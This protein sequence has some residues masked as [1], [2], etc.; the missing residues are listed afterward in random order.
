MKRKILLTFMLCLVFLGTVVFAAD[1]GY[2]F[3]LKYEGKV[4]VDEAKASSVTLT[5]TDA[6]PYTNVRIKVDIVSGPATPTLLAYDSNGIGYNIAEIGFWGPEAGFAVGGTFTNETPVTATFPQVGTYVINLSLIDVANNDAII[7]SKEF[8]VTVVT[9]TIEE[10]AIPENNVI[11]NT[12]TTTVNNT[13]ANIPQAGI[14]WWAY[15]L[16]IAAVIV[17]AWAIIT[18]IKNK[19]N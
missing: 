13:I 12:P 11:I 5:G 17:A 1:Q 2:E 9:N 19:E 16:V 3:D 14:S 8:T 7:T 6:T 4:V 10:P 18:F 15:V